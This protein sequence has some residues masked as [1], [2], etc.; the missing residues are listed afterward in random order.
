M[1]QP[2]F[3]SFLWQ[4]QLSELERTYQVVLGMLG[5]PK[6]QQLYL[7]EKYQNDLSKYA[8]LARSDDEIEYLPN[9]PEFFRR[10]MILVLKVH[11]EEICKEFISALGDPDKLL[12]GKK[13]K[14]R[15]PHTQEV[16]DSIKPH[17]G[18]F[19][20]QKIEDRLIDLHKKRNVFAHELSLEDTNDDT[21]F[22]ESQRAMNEF[23]E[24]LKSACASQNIIDVRNWDNE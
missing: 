14:E 1:T 7:D 2:R 23:I 10:Q 11:L 6:I 4:G 8:G 17:T 22:I 16:L 13:N 12:I 24:I 3:E 9:G 15:R 21:F 5:N 19:I 20:P 18:V